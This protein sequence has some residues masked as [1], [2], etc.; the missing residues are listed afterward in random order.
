MEGEGQ[1]ERERERERE[2]VRLE[3]CKGE[4]DCF[5]MLNF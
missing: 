4:E 1:R 3:E 5:V 2:Y